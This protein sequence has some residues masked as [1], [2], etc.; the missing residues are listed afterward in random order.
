[1]VIYG[2]HDLVCENPKESNKQKSLTGII[3]ISLASSQ[4][5]RST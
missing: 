3:N 1:M 2:W 5:I 4:N